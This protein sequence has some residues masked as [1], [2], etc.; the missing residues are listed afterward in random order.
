MSV[1]PGPRLHQLR[2]ERQ[3]TQEELARILVEKYGCRTN[4]GMISKYERNE[5]EMKGYLAA[6]I[7]EIFNVDVAYI[8]GAQETKT[9]DKMAGFNKI[10]LLGQIAAGTPIYAE[11]NKEGYEWVEESANVNFCLRVKG[12]SMIGAR[13]YDGDIVYIRQ[14]PDVEHGEIAAV[15]VDGNEA[16]L[17]RIYKVGNAIILHS[18]NLTIEDQTYKGKEAKQIVIIGKAIMIKGLVK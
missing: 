5:H 7:A 10:P 11:E 4:K 8:T 1:S 12:N 9:S 6:C 14:Q 18:E 3:M 2:K 16:T 15:R 17:K 13:I